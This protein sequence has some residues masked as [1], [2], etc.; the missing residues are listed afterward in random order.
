MSELADLVRIAQEGR[1]ALMIGADLPS[2]VSG[3]LSTQELAT[4]LAQY[5]ETSG[6]DSLARI[7]E[8]SKKSHQPWK[9]INYLRLVYPK[10]P[11]PG[12]V[13]RTIAALPITYL[14]TSAYDNLLGLALKEAHLTC[15]LLIQDHDAWRP[16]RDRDL[17]KLCGDLDRVETLVVAASDYTE[18]ITDKHRTDILKRVR[19]WLTDKTVLLIGCDPTPASDFENYVYLTVLQHLGGFQTKGYLVW[20]QAVNDSDRQR[21]SERRVAILPQDPLELLKSLQ[22]ELG[23]APAIR[24]ED[25]ESAALRELVKMLAGQPA[26]SAVAD[27]LNRIP[28]RQ[29]PVSIRTTIRLWLE[30]N[31]SLSAILDIDYAP[32]FTHYYGKPINTDCTLTDLNDWATAA[33]QARQAPS[34]A[35]DEA[36]KKLESQC[37]DLFDRILRADLP[38]RTKYGLALRDSQV[39]NA[40]LELVIALQDDLLSPMPWE[41]LNDGH[42]TDGTVIVGRGFLGQKYPLYRLPTSV[43]GLDQVTGQIKAALVVAADPSGKLGDVAAETLWI[44]KTLEAE[45]IKVDTCQPDGPEVQDPETIKTL[46]R[47]GKYQLLHFIGHGLFKP[48]KAA[49]SYLQLG[50]KGQSSKLITATDLA[51]AARESNL[52][53]VFLSACHGATEAQKSD[54]PWK[55]A[56]LM[57]ALTRAGVPVSVGMRWIVADTNSHKLAQE[58]YKHLMGGETAEQALL[59]ARQSLGSSF[60]WANPI[61]TKRHGI[62]G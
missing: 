59:H 31:K 48:R 4:G 46:L 52:V 13:H 19:E 38:D 39:L 61:L 12:E 44:K 37:L 50:A 25:K 20:P 34:V 7:A 5:S 32:N 36:V 56:G 41:L 2:T 29:R 55:E 47:S 18:L 10:Q 60:D 6:S 35:Q 24:P 15:N 62:L 45:G 43:S 42:V 27:T 17:I 14:M 57:D 53:L 28:L 22:K 1:L 3:L 51:D 23:P 26:P 40:T 21:W 49:E 30:K 54:Q 8:V 9:Y 16:S 11:T 58:F 33:E